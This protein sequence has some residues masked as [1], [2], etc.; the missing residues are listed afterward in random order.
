MPFSRTYFTLSA[1]II[2]T[3]AAPEG[4]LPELTHIAAL[5]LFTATLDHEGAWTFT[6]DAA[7]I[8][9]GEGET[10]LL[11]WAADRLP[12]ADT[13]I[14]WQ[15]AGRLLP[16]LL[17]AAQHAKPP[18]AHHFTSRLARVTRGDVVDLSI[19]HGGAAALPFNE[20]ADVHELEVPSLTPPELLSMWASG[21][22]LPVR[23]A[24]EAEVIALWRASLPA[25]A[26]PAD[27][28]AATENWL[29]SR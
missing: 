5:G 19:D 29:A 18:A 11:E 15:L 27:A 13:L 2:T 26:A 10:T 17:D 4:T 6:V 22:V 23:D 24:M 25:G 14:G 1:A 7:A 16:A 20:W 9:A 21:R 28:I 8:G 3:P 12:P